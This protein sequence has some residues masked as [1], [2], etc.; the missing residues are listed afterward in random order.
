LWPKRSGQIEA[1]LRSEA[2]ALGH[3]R[4]SLPTFFARAKKVLISKE[5]QR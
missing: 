2:I 5:L 3:Q 1:R 4:V